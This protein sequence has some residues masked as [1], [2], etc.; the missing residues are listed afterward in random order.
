LHISL[1]NALHQDNVTQASYV[2]ATGKMSD[3]TITP[4]AVTVRALLEMKL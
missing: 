3:T 1:A 2:D 4:T